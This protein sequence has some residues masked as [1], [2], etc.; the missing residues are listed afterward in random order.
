VDTPGYFDFSYAT[1]M[2]RGAVG[3]LATYAGGAE[4]AVPEPDCVVI[5]I[6]VTLTRLARR[7]RG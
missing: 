5:L 2:T 4:T 6:A 1:N 7:R 3:Y